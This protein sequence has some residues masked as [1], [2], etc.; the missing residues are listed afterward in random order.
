[1]NTS[2]RMFYRHAS[3]RAYDWS[4]MKDVLYADIETFVPIAI[5]YEEEHTPRSSYC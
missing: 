1:M 2:G 4:S 3:K 5:A